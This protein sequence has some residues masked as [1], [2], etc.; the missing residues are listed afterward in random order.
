MEGTDYQLKLYYT[1]A[2]KITISC[3]RNR[4]NVP[5]LVETRWKIRLVIG[6]DPDASRPLD[7]LSVPPLYA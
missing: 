5:L 6:F 1:V 3:F 4:G 7:G 2:G